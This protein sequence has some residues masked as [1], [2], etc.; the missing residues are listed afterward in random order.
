[1]KL[2]P[3]SSER[4]WKRAATR[5][6]FW[7][8]LATMAAITLLHYLT[9]QIR[10]LSPPMNAF[11]SR[12]AVERI[13]FIFPIAG[14]TF[15]FGQG[16]G[17]LILSLAVLVMLPRALWLSP[18]PIDALVETAATAV[19][20]YLVTWMI[21]F[22]T[23]E[24]ALRQKT[25]VQ[26]SAINQV[27]TIVT[28]SLELEQILNDAL[29]KVLEVTGLE[30]GLI[31]ERQDRDLILAAH[32]GISDTSTAELG[33]LKLGEGFYGRVVQSGEV[34]AT[35]DSLHDPQSTR[36]DVEKEGL[37]SQIVVPL[38]SKGEIQGV[39]AVATRRSH[40]FLPE[41]LELV[42]VIGN[43]IGVAIENAQLHR[44]V[45]RQLEIQQQ[46]NKVVE[47]ITS[48][49]ELDRILPKVLQIAE[50]LVGADGGG[51]ALFDP[52]RAHIR[53]PYLHNLPQ[54][55]ANVP[56]PKGQGVAGE[57]MSTGRPIVVENYQAYPGA[58]AAFSEAGITGV[59]A[60]PIVS[61]DRSFG[62]LTLV[63][64]EKVNHFSDRDITIL[65]G[66]GRQTGIAI[67]NARL[68][69]N[70]RFYIHQITQ[71]QED[72]R[73]R[74]ARDL[75]DETIQM[76]IVISRRLEM[77]ATLSEQLPEAAWPHLESLQELIGATL[78]RIRR[79][80]QD[81]RP[82]TLDYLGLMATLEGL[83]ANLREKDHIETE[84]QATGEVRRLS[85]DEELVLFRIVQESLNNVRR[86]AGA[87]HVLVQVEFHPDKV[88]IRI[89]DDGCGFNAPERIGDLVSSGRFGLIGMYERARTLDGTLSIRSE[90]GQGTAVIV[91]APV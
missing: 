21:E 42:T 81:L 68:Y 75:H 47:R 22:Q 12:H 51:I 11:L 19:I 71:A 37:R 52:E 66:I 50:E 15:A 20:G 34:M 17:W 10:F 67:E 60:A 78:K 32:R 28:S 62:A 44:D 83:V 14:A 57:V 45:A 77:L 35:S 54:E 88:A 33:R 79:F 91:E 86:H 70:L 40:E 84:V 90:P 64:L 55:L 18:S 63:S 3:T 48:E 59:V 76:L 30:A 36:L 27:A 8:I 41:E 2:T 7:V 85:P 65:S 13:L 5:A 43:Q 1:M 26:L 58:I 23:R 9:P 89:K 29:A 49:L 4:R 16:G 87:S 39:L 80:L 38:K 31:F 73:K 72:E 25:I 61:G 74:I 69:E 53:Y 24:K 46:L 6:S 82:P 56:I